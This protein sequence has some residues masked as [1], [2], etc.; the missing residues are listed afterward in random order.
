MKKILCLALLV[1]FLA[2]CQ[3]NEEERQI[4]IGKWRYDPVA[5]IQDARERGLPSV[6][7]KAIEG[8]MSV[9]QNVIF[10]FKED[11]TLIMD[12]PNSSPISGTWRLTSNGEKMAISL[13]AE[14][15]PGKLVE[16]SEERII[17]SSEQDSTLQFTRIFIPAE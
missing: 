12:S 7:V 6:R 8:A 2:A 14:G 15:V 16:L 4:I 1:S 11:G 5:I 17:I 13:S 10:D 9:Y 3:N